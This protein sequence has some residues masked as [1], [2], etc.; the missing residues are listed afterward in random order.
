MWSRLTHNQR[1]AIAVVETV[2]I[3]G[4]IVASQRTVSDLLVLS[5]IVLVPT[6][7]ILTLRRGAIAGLGIPAAILGLVALLRSDERSQCFAIWF[8]A[9]S[10]ALLA[11][12]IRA[13][14]R[15][16]N[17]PR[18]SPRGHD[19]GLVGVAV[20]NPAPEVRASDILAQ[21]GLDDGSME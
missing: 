2:A 9:A 10:C 17:Q 13:G 5:S 12:A 18:Q 4:L 19:S 3:Y 21:L 15:R 8:V 16:L 20:R 1:F 7:V 14:T 11:L 6:S